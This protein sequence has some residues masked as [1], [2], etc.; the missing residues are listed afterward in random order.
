VIT[1]KWEGD[2]ISVRMGAAALAGAMVVLASGAAAQQ[3]N[4]DW[5]EECDDWGRRGQVV[6]CEVRD[7]PVQAT[8]SLDL[9]TTN[10]IVEVCGAQRR[11]VAVRVR[12]RAWA[13]T[14]EEAV[15]RAR[16]VRV[17]ADGGR[18]RADGRGDDWTVDYAASVPRSYDV[19]VSTANG[20]LEVCDVSGRVHA[21]TRNGPAE[22]RGVAGEVHART[23][24]GPLTVE[25]AGNSVGD[26]GVDVRTDNG[27]LT[28]VVP[29]GM[30]ARLE[31]GTGN[32]PI[33]SDLDVP[34]RRHSRWSVSG[35]IDATLGSGGGSIRARTS[36]G[37][38][39]IRE[40]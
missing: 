23:N 1:D 26:G 39:S 4:A 34:V 5:L 24:N 22:L 33:S 19:R 15:E 7:V 35:D 28:L 36:N 31:A 8:G 13:D 10:G 11:D 17:S 21:E 40:D 2:V 9:E 37:P 27:P 14:R 12:V 18:V 30:N 38:L 32:G 3:P 20:P 6:H 25:L 16:A 29:R